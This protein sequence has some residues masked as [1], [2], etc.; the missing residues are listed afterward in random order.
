MKLEK[1]DMNHHGTQL[2][3]EPWNRQTV[4][5]WRLS[6]VDLLQPIKKREKANP[7][8]GKTCAKWYKRLILYLPSG[9]WYNLDVALISRRSNI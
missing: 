2:T 9:A 8:G 4:H 3:G 5:G 6:C 1:N 7:G